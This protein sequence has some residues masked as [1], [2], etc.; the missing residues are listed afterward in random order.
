VPT[1][2]KDINQKKKR[3]RKNQRMSATVAD[4]VDL[5]MHNGEKLRKTGKGT[6]EK[7][8]HRP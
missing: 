3:K 8:K 1:D 7:K 5:K 2:Q 6:N 4:Q